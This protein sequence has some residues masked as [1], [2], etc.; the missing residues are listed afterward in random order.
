VN[1]IA[2]A[3]VLVAL[4]VPAGAQ[5]RQQRPAAPAP[6][7]APAP[8]PETLLAYEPQL[9]R[10]SEAL[11][12]IA[13][14]SQLCGESSSDAWRQRAEQLIEAEAATQARKERLAGAYNRGFTGHQAAHRACGERAR[15]VIE[16]KLKE[17]REITQDI[18]NRFGG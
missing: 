7:P 15:L 2:L 17:A 1:R 3:A 8:E 10:L 14:M 11:G 13:F 9:L 6:A 4:A 18:A 16:R 5:Q 12:V